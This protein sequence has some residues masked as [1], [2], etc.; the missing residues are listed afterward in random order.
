MSILEYIFS[1][2]TTLKDPAEWFVNAL[3]GRK[4]A[5]GMRVNS[6]TAMNLA[7][8][9]AG[10]RAISEDVAKLPFKVFEQLQPR[11]K[12][13]IPG[14]RVHHLLQVEPN[15]DMGSMAF[16]E[17]MTHWALGWGGGIAEIQRDG[18]GMAE[19]LWPIHPSRVKLDRDS[20]RQLIY[21][22]RTDDV[23]KDA[24]Q[25]EHFVAIPSR[26]V[27]HIHGLSSD[28]IDG[29]SILA[30]ASETLGLGLAAQ[31]FGAAFFGNGAA[32]GGVLEHPKTLSDAAH[33]RLRESW[34]ADYEGPENVA[35]TL[36]AEEGMKY[37]K[38][39]IPPEEAQFL[40]TR[41]FTVEDIARWFRI[42]PHKLQHLL[43]STF[44]NIEQQSIEYVTDTLMP[45]LIRWEQEIKR[46]LFVVGEESL[47]AEHVVQ[48]LLRGDQKT[49]GEFYTKQLQTG[50]LSPNDIR[51]LE[52]RNPIE[53]GDTYYIPM[54]L[55]PVDSVNDGSA[56]SKG[57][58]SKPIERK[59]PDAMAETIK[60][61]HS[62][63]IAD[64]VSR[65]VNKECKAVKNAVKKYADKQTAFDKW[66]EKFFAEHQTQLVASLLPTVEAMVQL[67]S[68]GSNVPD[69]KAAEIWL[70]GLMSAI[71]EMH[72]R[73]LAWVLVRNN[74]LEICE[75]WIIKEPSAIAQSLTN[76]F[77]L[78]ED[79][80]D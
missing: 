64:I 61:A 70:S 77:V 19:A 12:K 15:P 3:G 49:R 33:K 55:A 8:Y 31:T 50:A 5:S 47:L 60:I 4:T 46:K 21:V 24:K 65:L 1:G 34:G 69:F 56:R 37:S 43:R 10:L 30:M 57:A 7:P 51:E 42:P 73:E 6:R 68:K 23:S 32:I 38:R 54:N 35:K 25:R 75:N 71:C 80:N 76:W 16:R 79:N 48:A 40:E 22:V 27:L 18:S 13:S 20:N 26:D 59:D 28:G 44:S 36:I 62:R 52:N 72:N 39:S 53:G 14:H 9:Y 11:G 78:S 45:W 41:Q 17:T 63:I 67:T 2:S 58:S 29:Y 66:R 74:C